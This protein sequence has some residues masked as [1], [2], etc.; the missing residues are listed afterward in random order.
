MDQVQSDEQ[1]LAGFAAGDRGALGA[2]AE[3]YETSMLGFA[4]GMLGSDAAAMDAVQETW[5]RVIRHAG[6]FRGHSSVKTWLYQ[7]LINR[8]RD[9]RRVAAGGPGKYRTGPEDPPQVGAD[10]PAPGEVAERN[11]TLRAA[12]ESLPEHQR[13]V[14]LLCY[15][16]GMTHRVAARVLGIPP[17]TLKSRLNKALRELR[18]RLPEEMMS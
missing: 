8:C 12:V 15:H 1:L 18:G 6:G 7:I 3:R 2:L 9:M 11:G 16:A 14:L 4:R 13:D 10:G 17:G 5:L